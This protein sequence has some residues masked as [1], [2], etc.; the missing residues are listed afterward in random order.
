MGEHWANLK[1]KTALTGPLYGTYNGKP[2][3]SEI[4]VTQKQLQDGFTYRNLTALP[5]YTINHVDFNFEPH[6]HPGMPFPHYDLHAY[7]VSA[8]EQEKICPGG[9]PDPSMKS[10]M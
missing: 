8:A 1:S 7:Y 10:K 9:V 5:G 2:V 3:F 6:G 4:M